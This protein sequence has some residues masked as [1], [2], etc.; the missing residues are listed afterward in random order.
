MVRIAVLLVLGAFTL[1]GCA[2]ALGGAAAI[3]ADEAAEQQGGN[4]F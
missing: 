3:A 1:S 2:V 4:L